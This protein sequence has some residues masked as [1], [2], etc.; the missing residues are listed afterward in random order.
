M[1]SPPAKRRRYT[2]ED[3]ERGLWTLA[4]NAGR[5]DAAVEALKAQ[6]HNIPKGT[7][8]SWARRDH[9]ERYEEI[10]Q[11]ASHQIAQRV[12]AQAE[13]FMLAA[14]EVEM[15]ALQKLKGEIEQDQIEGKDLAGAL[16]N[17]STSKALNNDK[18][19]APIRGRPTQITEHR[20]AAQIVA[21][22]K[23]LGVVVEGTAQELPPT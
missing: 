1:P 13:Q 18:I 3:I 12:A 2:L 7:L 16:R 22:L 14:G 17:V 21:E 19:S 4:L 10:K 20:D 5:E 23:K 15:L 6:G 9:V 11:E 8:G